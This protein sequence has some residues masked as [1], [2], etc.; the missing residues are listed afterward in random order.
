MRP[1]YD[2]CRCRVAGPLTTRARI[3][4]LP[5][6][7]SRDLLA[8]PRERHVAPRSAEIIEMQAWPTRAMA[9]GGRRLRREVITQPGDPLGPG[10]DVP[11]CVNQELKLGLEPQLPSDRSRQA[12]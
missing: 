4:T 7:I 6:E 3:D 1:G 12:E 11:T 9:R 2:T 10:Q 5:E 8:R